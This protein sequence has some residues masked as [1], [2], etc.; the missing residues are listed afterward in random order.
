MK[1]TACLVG[2][3][4]ALTVS[5]EPG[6]A[7]AP[8]PGIERMYVLYCGDI[9][10]TDMGRFSP[11]YSGP[12]A[13][14]STCYLIKHAQG[15][16]LWDSGLP[17]EI[18]SIPEGRRSPAGV[19]HVKKTLGSQLAEIGVKPADIRYLALSHSHND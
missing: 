10:L 2:A 16:L 13:L 12:G 19:W 8:K 7:Q 4:V 1:T 6:L 14:S 3:M 18:A 11:G 9:A 17:D 15:W 5:I